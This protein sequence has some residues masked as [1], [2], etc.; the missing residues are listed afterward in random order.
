MGKH[1]WGIGCCLRCARGLAAVEAALVFPAFFAMIFGIIEVSMFMNKRS[2]VQYSC[3]AAA[4]YVMTNT[5]L[6]N[7]QIT[8]YAQTKMT[9]WGATGVTF[10]VTRTTEYG[11]DYVAINGS[12]T[13]T[14]STIMFRFFHPTVS[15][16]ARAPI[17]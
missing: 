7:A 14:S 8:A 9:G 1:P 15:L 4:R 10:S 12:F 3:D 16:K 13:Y 2:G 6:T 11:A 17:S 5:T